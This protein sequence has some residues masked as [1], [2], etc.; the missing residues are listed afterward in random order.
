[1]RPPY[2]RF[3]R[4]IIG[5]ILGVFFLIDVKMIETALF[6]GFNFFDLNHAIAENLNDKTAVEDPDLWRPILG[7]VFLQGVLVFVWLRL[8][9]QSPTKTSIAP[10]I[11]SPAPP[12]S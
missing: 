10:T 8:R 6:G 5:C 4:F 11:S 12:N 1:M 7:L 9:R 3:A 2:I